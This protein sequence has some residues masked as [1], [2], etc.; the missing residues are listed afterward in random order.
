M[1][2]FNNNACLLHSIGEICSECESTIHHIQLKCPELF[3]C[4]SSH[5]PVID[6][7]LNNTIIPAIK[8][9]HQ[10][11]H[12][13][14]STGNLQLTADTAHNLLSDCRFL[15]LAYE[16]AK[17]HEQI[18][19]EDFSFDLRDHV[20]ASCPRLCDVY[21]YNSKIREAFLS[22]INEFMVQKP[23]QQPFLP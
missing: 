10:R 4:S 2:C 12:V 15:R 22:A 9:V 3:A 19:Y 8:R 6:T 5:D 11:V 13:I 20:R 7:V 16:Q 21:L 1:A 23:R 18:G 17:I 14:K